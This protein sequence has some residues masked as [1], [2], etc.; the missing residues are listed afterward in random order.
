M[1]DSEIGEMFAAY[2]AA[3]KAKKADNTAFSTQLLIEQGIR[4]ERKNGGA[5]LIVEAG[6]HHVDFWPSGGRWIARDKPKTNGRG[7]RH[8]LRHIAKNTQERPA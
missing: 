6:D 5:H 2:N 8:L 3:R 1:S 7:V 4:F